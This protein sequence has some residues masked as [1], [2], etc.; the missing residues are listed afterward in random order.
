MKESNGKRVNWKGLEE[1]LRRLTRPRFALESNWGIKQV[2]VITLSRLKK[3]E[4]LVLLGVMLIRR[5]GDLSTLRA[6]QH[7]LKCQ[8]KISISRLASN[9]IQG[10]LHRN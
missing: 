9:V 1:G 10:G 2:D 5:L 3:Q 7:V 6:F 4:K 8:L